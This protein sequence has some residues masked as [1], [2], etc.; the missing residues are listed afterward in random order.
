M[1]MLAMI[2]AWRWDRDDDLP[3][4]RQ[5]ALTWL[6]ELRAALGRDDLDMA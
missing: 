5:L 4:G 6:S 3:N 2:V 1:L